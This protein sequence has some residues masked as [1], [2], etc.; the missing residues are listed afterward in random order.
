MLLVKPSHIVLYSFYT[1]LILLSP[2]SY[3]DHL[4]NKQKSDPKIA[5]PQLN[6]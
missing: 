1:V 6:M 4:C 5:F 3:R 2:D